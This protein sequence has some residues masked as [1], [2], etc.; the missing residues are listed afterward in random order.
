MDYQDWT[1]VTLSVTKNDPVGV[2]LREVPI[3]M[4]VVRI[5]SI[6]H[7]INQLFLT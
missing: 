7:G 3:A 4:S 6:I 5:S 1:R 2:G